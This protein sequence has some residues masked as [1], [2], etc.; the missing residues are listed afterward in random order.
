MGPPR[1]GWSLDAK[2]TAVSAPSS[3]AGPRTSKKTTAERASGVAPSTRILAYRGLYID[4]SISWHKSWPVTLGL[5][6]HH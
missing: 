1:A 2:V 6:A 4:E 5:V 3:R